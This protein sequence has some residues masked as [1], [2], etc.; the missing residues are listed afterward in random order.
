[1]AI[2][3]TGSRARSRKVEVVIELDG[4]TRRASR[5]AAELALDST[6]F[7]E[8]T[9]L[10]KIARYERDFPRVIRLADATATLEG[11]LILER[12]LIARAF[13]LAR[14]G[15]SADAV[16]DSL[17]AVE[18]AAS[19]TEIGHPSLH[20]YALALV[21]R[22]DEAR[23]SL[24]EGALRVRAGEDHVL[25][26]RWAAHTVAGYGALGEL[27]PGIALLDEVIDRPHETL[28]A[29]NLRLDPKFDPYR[30]DPRF[31]GIVDRRVQYEAENARKAE[32]G[33]PWVP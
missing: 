19:S 23:R 5:L 12:R 11:T 15:D 31:D 9:A 25:G 30:A 20:G 8:G 32:A 18:G 28:T 7:E 17:L 24:Q 6:S 27:D 33:R 29:T 4:H 3:P 14:L 2:G 22:P 21:G 1:M 26:S 16:V 10:E 13:A